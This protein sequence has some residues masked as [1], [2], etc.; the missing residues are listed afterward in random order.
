MSEKS[1]NYESIKKAKKQFYVVFLML[2]IL[3][4]NI[5]YSFSDE[6]V[7]PP[8]DLTGDPDE[9]VKQLQESDSSDSS[10]SLT[11]T[12]TTSQCQGLFA[13]NSDPTENLMSSIVSLCLPGIL[14]NL[15]RLEIEEC[16]K[17]LCEYEAAKNGLSPINCAKQS[18][19]N[20]C[21]ITG[22]GYDIIEGL[23]IGSLRQNIKRILENPLGLAISIA[24]KRIE[25][26]L[27]CNPT[28][29]APISKGAAIGL[30]A[31]EI[32]N[33]YGSLTQLIE[34]FENSQGFNDNACQE[35]E[36]IEKELEQILA[37]HNG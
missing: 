23:L 21:L 12:L 19:Y 10:T 31:I 2:L 5:Q 7:G 14:K 24:R 30:A 15:N 32:F 18:A 28:C 25:Q 3:S 16:E 37:S 8:V 27:L 1:G 4:M 6:A 9:A 17:I 22:E 29:S 20:T 35:L 34:Q 36:E 13:D 33:A 11:D 26:A